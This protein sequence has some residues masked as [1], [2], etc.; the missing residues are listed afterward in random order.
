[1]RTY[2]RFAAKPGKVRRET[3]QGR[4][5][6]VVPTVAL[7]EGVITA[8]NAEGPELVL[9]E[10][11]GHHP[12][13]WAGRPVM[14]NHPRADDGSMISA[15]DPTVLE[16][17][18]IGVTFAPVMKDR[19]LTI[20][21][22]VDIE[23]G[24]TLNADSAAIIQ[25]LEFS[26]SGG[27]SAPRI[28]VSI[29]AF[30][31]LEKQAG[32][33]NGQRYTGIWRN[34]VPDHLA[35]LKL[36]DLGACSIEM[37][38][39]APR[40]AAL[41]PKE[42]P[43]D[44]TLKAWVAKLRTAFR[45]PERPVTLQATDEERAAHQSM[46][47]VLAP[48]LLGRAAMTDV[49]RRSA[50]EISLRDSNPNFLGI[51]AVDD[52]AG[53]VIY[54]A[55]AEGG[56]GVRMYQTSYSTRAGKITLGDDKTEVRSE[57]KFVPA[58]AVPSAPPKA[59][60][61]CQQPET[62]V[63]HAT[64]GTDQKGDA[65]MKTKT[66]RVQAL[67]ESKKNGFS[68]KHK[69]QLE[70]LSDETLALLEEQETAQPEVPPAVVP[71]AEEQKQKTELELETAFLSAAPKSVRDT[72]EAAKVL[73]AR[74]QITSAA[75]KTVLVTELKTAQSAFTEPEL[76]AK[77]VEDL[78][79]LRSLLGLEPVDYSLQSVPRAASADDDVYNNP[80]RPWSLAVA[81]AKKTA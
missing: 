62:I 32:N 48:I 14:M 45:I 56:G 5:F 55:F 74:D 25:E 63:A 16:Q 34:V 73:I 42:S 26:E 31:D 4:D 15:N 60:C 81:A 7:V 24:K 80:P 33:W 71:P 70:A 21:G 27:S 19:K 1:V 49:D 18:Q 28:E 20:E 57:T 9:A 65:T 44:E 75:R 30:L 11:F 43:V 77:S 54:H 50:L 2:A 46:L 47:D 64:T 78:E 69:P 6:F 22:W 39:G 61:G 51:A 12:L 8:G 38:C 67:I 10:E 59:A 17:G 3:F 52:E 79:K 13:G 36:G 35:F 68:V 72:L 23:K 37:G 66:E 53:V 41:R 58:S 76:Q 29:G 40:A